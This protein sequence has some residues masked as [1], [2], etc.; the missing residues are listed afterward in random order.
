[1]SELERIR[2]GVSEAAKA[3][4]EAWPA[5]A[6]EVQRGAQ[7]VLRD[8]DPTLQSQHDAGRAI[9]H[10]LGRYR[11]AIP[12][13]MSWAQRV[14]QLRDIQTLIGFGREQSWDVLAT[15]VDAREGDAPELV[16]KLGAIYVP[17]QLLLEEDGSV[18]GLEGAVKSLDRL[19]TGITVSHAASKPAQM[20]PLLFRIL[21]THHWRA[22]RE[23]YDASANLADKKVCFDQFRHA[24]ETAKGEI[25]F[26]GY[27]E[28]ESFV[29]EAVE[30]AIVR[31]RVARIGESGERL[32]RPIKWVKRGAGWRLAGGLM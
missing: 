31:T 1:M 23:L 5:A 16:V 4:R 11:V 22:F 10:Q 9:L 27:D 17:G 2:M 3:R 25:A 6:G 21:E 7:I 15:V 29:D 18:P 12:M 19:Q 24:W 14:G 13:D 26:E 32:A 20:L 28:P 8:V 30:G